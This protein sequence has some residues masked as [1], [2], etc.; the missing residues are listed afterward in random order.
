MTIKY[1]TLGCKVNAIETD[2]LRRDLAALGFDQ[3]AMD[4]PAEVIVINTCS[5]TKQSDLKSARLIRSALRQDAIVIAMG[6]Y[7]PQDLNDQVLVIPNQDKHRAAQLISDHVGILDRSGSI[8]SEGERTRSFVKVQ[9]G[10]NNFCSYCII[11]Y[12]RGRERSL[13]QA[14]ILREVD[15]ALANGRREIVLSG[16]NLS[17]Y[18]NDTDTDLIEL[19]EIIA[20][21]ESI[22][23]I[24][25]GSLEQVIITPDFLQRLKNIDAFCPH[26][27][28]SLQ[29]GS[30]GVL[31]R[32]NRH[33]TPEEF[34]DKIDLI[35]STWSD[36]TITTDIIV[37][38]SG[39]TKEEFQETIDFVRRA[40]F[41]KVHVFP[42]S[43]RQ[44]TRAALLKDLPGDVK[45]DR[46]RQMRQITEAIQAELLDEWIGQA[47]EILTEESY[48]YTRHYLPVYYDDELEPNQLVMMKI[49]GRKELSLHGLP[50]LQNH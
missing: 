24:R 19:V 39:E 36:A 30:A 49:T 16:I 10:C 41:H 14:D 38:F 18:G 3:V 37:G 17:S 6:C 26:F 7:V 28:L 48:G 45:K 50:I 32:M 34:L 21:R 20:Q 46:A 40:R 5:V 4:D 42:Y 25:L 22:D 35:R 29:S 12:L 8:L 13:S 43:K 31:K 44:G 33:Y 47:V 9:D 27:H 2:R 23:R 15:R 11:P 1:H